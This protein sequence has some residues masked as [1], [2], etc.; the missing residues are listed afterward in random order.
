MHFVGMYFMSHTSATQ[1]LM[2]WEPLGDCPYNIHKKSNTIESFT[3][4]HMM[5]MYSPP[6]HM[7]SEPLGSSQS[8]MSS[9]MFSDIDEPSSALHSEIL[10]QSAVPITLGNST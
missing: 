4:T 6:Y 5:H 3:D 10:S 1:S 2:D 8:I 9:S 7:I